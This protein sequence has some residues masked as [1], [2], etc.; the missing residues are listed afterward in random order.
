[1]STRFVVSVAMACF[2]GALCI[3]YLPAAETLDE[4][5]FVEGQPLPEARP[6]EGWKLVCR[7]AIYKSVS[8]TVEISPASS[9]LEPIAAKWESQS[10]TI[11][12]A[13]ETRVLSAVPAKHETECFRVMTRPEST[14][15]EVIPARYETA[16][17]EV[18]I[19]AAREET[20]CCPAQYR[21]ESERIE[22]SPAYTYWKKTSGEKTHCSTCDSC[23][24]KIS[25]GACSHCGKRVRSD[26]SA[27]CG[28]SFCLVE[29]PAKFVTVCKQV[30]DKDATSETI[31]IPAR[32]KKVCVQRLV[33]D[34]EVRKTVIPAEYATLERGVCG[35]C[36]V[37]CTS[38]PAKFETICKQV[39]AEPAA[40]RRVDIPA[41]FETVCKQVLDQPASM[42]WRRITCNSCDVCSRYNEIPGTD[43]ASLLLLRK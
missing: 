42:V 26:D 10:V 27:H 30:I 14:C 5:P 16:E 11:Q 37:A 32:T 35:K 24:E 41:K 33:A 28:D 21:T 31:T 40:T 29:V 6:G 20:R 13:P 39:L 1:M 23:G 15:L 17:E 12:V 25:D 19:E 9:Y 38:I 2:V 8:E 34:A 36:D 4:V 22:V 7:P 18:V 3:G 43:E